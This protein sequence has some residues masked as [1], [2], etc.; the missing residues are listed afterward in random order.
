MK[1]KFKKFIYL[2]NDITN[3]LLK[4]ERVQ[5]EENAKKLRVALIIVSIILLLSLVLNIYF[6]FK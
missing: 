1:F 4:K 6:C 2:I 5:T 3:L